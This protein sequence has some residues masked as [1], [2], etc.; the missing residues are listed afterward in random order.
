MKRAAECLRWLMALAGLGFWLTGFSVFF[1]ADDSRWRWG[2]TEPHATHDCFSDIINPLAVFSPIFSLLLAY[3]IARYI[4][5]MWAPQPEARGLNWWPASRHA[6]GDLL[7]PFGQLIAAAGI[8]T[9]LWPL[10]A[11]P[12]DWG[13]FWPYYLYWGASALWCALTVWIAWPPREEVA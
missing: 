4:F 11:F 3:P 9:S 10:H 13:F 1:S 12:P 7:W 2:C 5:T 8:F 6:G